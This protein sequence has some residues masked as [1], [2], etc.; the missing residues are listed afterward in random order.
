M[1]PQN[2]ARPILVKIVF[3]ERDTGRT[4]TDRGV[5]LVRSCPGIV[6]VQFHL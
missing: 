3:N 1:Y 2:L 6:S 4:G 5:Q